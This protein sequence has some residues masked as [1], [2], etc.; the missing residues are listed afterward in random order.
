MRRA[1]IEEGPAT[2]VG[3]TSDVQ[4]ASTDPAGPKPGSNYFNS[5]SRWGRVPFILRARTV[6]PLMGRAPFG[7]RHDP[8][9]CRRDFELFA[10][11][12]RCLLVLSPSIALARAVPDDQPAIEVTKQ[13][14]V[15]RGRGP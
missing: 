9:L 5:R 11:R 15:N 3:P 4:S 10:G 7:I 8:Q 2:A 13:H 1:R 6:Q 12:P 14:L